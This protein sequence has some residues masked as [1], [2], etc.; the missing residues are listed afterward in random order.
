MG[1]WFE[2]GLFHIP[3]GNPESRRKMKQIVDEL[4][5]YPSGRTTDTVMAL[6][7]AWRAAQ[8]G[9]NRMRTVNRLHN[10]AHKEFWKQQTK[11]RTLRN[12]YY[13]DLAS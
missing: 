13:A 2:N 4:I 8:M 9:L 6:W 11:R 5:M 12:P 10:G 3:N 1:P 7:F